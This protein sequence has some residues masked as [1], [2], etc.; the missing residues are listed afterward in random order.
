MHSSNSAIQ[1]QQLMPQI[2]LK[3][4]SDQH[5][6]PD[7]KLTVQ[8]LQELTCCWQ[9]QQRN[10]RRQQ[11]T[12]KGMMQQ[13]QQLSAGSGQQLHEAHQGS[14]LWAA[15]QDIQNIQK[16]ITTY[17]NITTF[18]TCAFIFIEVYGFCSTAGQANTGHGYK[19]LLHLVIH[20]LQDTC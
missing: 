8:S 3:L 10:K 20:Y 5:A 18:A 6:H 9:A 13:H 14:R 1:Q 7:N 12:Q 4:I 11:R 16:T 17:Y 2:V 15:F 19:T